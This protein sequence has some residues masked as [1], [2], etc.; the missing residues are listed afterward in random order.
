MTNQLISVAVNRR[1]RLVAE[2][3][4]VSN[5]SSIV[6]SEIIVVHF[7]PNASNVVGENA[8]RN[9]NINST[10]ERYASICIVGQLAAHNIKVTEKCVNRRFQS[11]SM[12][13]TQ[14]HCGISYGNVSRRVSCVNDAV[15]F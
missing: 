4:R 11:N 8:V 2:E 12:S 3:F 1:I 14:R 9:R 7:N 6:H 5:N 13:S 10:I 15:A